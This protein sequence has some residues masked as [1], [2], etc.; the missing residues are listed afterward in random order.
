MSHLSPIPEKDYKS[1]LKGLMF[2][3]LLF[4]ALLLGVTIVLQL[5]DSTTSME[6]SFVVLYALIIAIFL[7]SMIY[8][9]LLKR[10][11]KEVT[12]AFVQTGVDTFFVTLIIFVTGGFISV[13]T[14]LYLLVIIYSSMLLPMR[15]TMVIAALCSLQFGCLVELEY[16]GILDPLGTNGNTL[17]S[18]YDWY[19]ILAVCY[20]SRPENPKKSFARWK[21]MSSGLKRWR[22]SG[23]WQPV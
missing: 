7:I 14:F 16:F 22:P 1:K 5:S 20:R 10:I 23:R 13:F 4:S 21:V 15:G 18:A 6:R 19:Q 3:R 17:S 8:S 12:F 11:K 9:L 2:F